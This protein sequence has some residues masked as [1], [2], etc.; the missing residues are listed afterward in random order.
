MIIYSIYN[1][2][3]VYIDKNVLNWFLI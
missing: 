1:I 2:Y 3:T